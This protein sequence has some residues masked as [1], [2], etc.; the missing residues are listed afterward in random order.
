MTSVGVQAARVQLYMATWF[1]DR[2]TSTSTFQGKD[3]G[4]FLTE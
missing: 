1:T 4:L 2:W 3:Q